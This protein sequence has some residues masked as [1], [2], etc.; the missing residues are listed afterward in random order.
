MTSSVGFAKPGIAALA[1]RPSILLQNRIWSG[2]NLDDFFEIRSV[3]G[4]RGHP[5]RLF[6]SGCC[7]NIRSTFLLSVS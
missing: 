3:L 1:L 4:T 2:V 7:S 6:K 5:F